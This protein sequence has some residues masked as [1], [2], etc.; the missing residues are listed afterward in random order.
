MN[1]KKWRC[2][3]LHFYFNGVNWNDYPAYFKRGTFVRRE[4]IE[5]KYTCEELEKLPEQH[6]ARSNPDLTI[7]RHEYVTINMPVFK[8]VVNR[9][10]VIFGGEPPLIEEE[11]KVGIY[12]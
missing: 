6:Q 4:T 5:R 9:V 8:R 11:G 7:K 1:K 3:F 12:K 2:S 10:G